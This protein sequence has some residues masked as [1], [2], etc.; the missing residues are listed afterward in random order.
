M[1]KMYWWEGYYGYKRVLARVIKR[2]RPYVRNFGDQLSPFIIE[3]R[4]KLS[5]SLINALIDL[6]TVITPFNFRS[7]FH[8]LCQLHFEYAISGD[9]VYAFLYDIAIRSKRSDIMHLYQHV[10]R[11]FLTH[12]PELERKS[13]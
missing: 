6:G 2:K 5:V 1:I 10:E 9:E 7:I 4:E 8:L 12:G 3:H 11:I 13:A